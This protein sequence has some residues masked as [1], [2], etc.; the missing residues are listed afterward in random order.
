[1]YVLNEVTFF[2]SLIEQNKYNMDQNQNQNNSENL[3][4]PNVKYV[5]IIY[6]EEEVKV[7][8]KVRK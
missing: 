6:P 3:P 4:D 5:E 8:K 1:M 2:Y 7:I